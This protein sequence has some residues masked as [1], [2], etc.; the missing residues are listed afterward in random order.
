MSDFTITPTG[1]ATRCNIRIGDDVYGQVDTTSTGNIML[2]RRLSEE[3]I[4]K[5]K[6][7]VGD[8]PV[9]QPPPDIPED[10]Q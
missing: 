7:V 1:V 5:L 9:I 6:R 2:I 3:Q 8:R 10:W 4:A